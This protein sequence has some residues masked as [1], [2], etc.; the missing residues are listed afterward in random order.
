MSNWSRRSF[1]RGAI[2]A[3]TAPRLLGCDAS[4]TDLP[5]SGPARLLARPWRP[6]L[7]PL[8]GE[9]TQLG[10][11]SARDGLLYV[12]RSYFSGL[13]MPLMVVLHGAGG[14]ADDWQSYW[15]RAERYG[16]IVL[17]PESR[18][19]TWDRVRGS[20]GPDVEFLDA[21]LTHTFDRCRVDASRIALAGFS[22]GASYA[23]SL[24]AAN[25]DLFSHLIAYS[26]GFYAPGRP[27]IGR[28]RIFVSH[29]TRDGIFSHWLT[30]NLLVPRLEAAGYDVTFRSFDEGH[31]VP[32]AISEA[33]ITWF[34]EGRGSSLAPGALQA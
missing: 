25:G 20:W 34:V 24:G 14:A 12:P 1:L 28:P 13:P 33:A 31:T 29:G 6:R 18:S 9:V 4:P 30:E 32:A 26:P 10:L 5:A 27:T 22:D 16:M 17:A 3:L 15:A 21:A 19:G 11:G 2:G 23:L 7:K 8:R